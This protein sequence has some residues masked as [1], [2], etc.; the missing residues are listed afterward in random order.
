MVSMALLAFGSGIGGNP[1]GDA[2]PKL[3]RGGTIMISIPG[4]HAM[5]LGYAFGALT[6]Y[7]ADICPFLLSYQVPL[8]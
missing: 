6:R 2:R 4:R 7:G 8:K 5:K 1:C 3:E